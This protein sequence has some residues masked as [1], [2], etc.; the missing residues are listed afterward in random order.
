MVH[1]RDCR[2]VR[3]PTLEH[4]AGRRRRKQPSP[5]GQAFF[6]V[7]FFLSSRPLD[8]PLRSTF[9]VNKMRFRTKQLVGARYGS[10]FQVNGDKSLELIESGE[11]DMPISFEIGVSSSSCRH[12]RTAQ[13]F[14]LKVH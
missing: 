6:H 1:R 3:S 8:R 11:L 5:P 12:R 4:Q 13:E 2:E 10:V 9:S 7:R 14:M